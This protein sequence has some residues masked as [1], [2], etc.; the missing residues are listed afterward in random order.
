[1]FVPRVVQKI[2]DEAIQLAGGGGVSQEYELAAAFAGVRAQRLGDG[3]DAVHLWQ[4]ARRELARAGE[5]TEKVNKRKE[6]EE[7]MLARYR[8]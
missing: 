5:V 6:K 3:P 1:V 2:V 7:Q 8:L 4:L